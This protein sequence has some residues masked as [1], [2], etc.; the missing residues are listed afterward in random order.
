MDFKIRISTNTKNLAPLRLI[1]LP[2][3]NHRDYKLKDLQFK[4]PFAGEL[5]IPQITKFTVHNS[6]CVVSVESFF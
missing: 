2:Q 1:L 6:T 3:N 5:S 4:T